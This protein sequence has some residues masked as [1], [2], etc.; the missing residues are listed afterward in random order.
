MQT[1]TRE[2]RTARGGEFAATCFTHSRTYE[3][4]RSHLASVSGLLERTGRAESNSNFA[5]DRGGPG[6]HPTGAH[7]TNLR[8]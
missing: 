7:R 2:S 3:Y 8:A 1:C 5:L 4:L 6:S